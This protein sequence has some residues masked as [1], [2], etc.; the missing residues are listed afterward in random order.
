VILKMI[1]GNAELQLSILA[2]AER[3]SALQERG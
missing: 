2:E 3:S 1:S